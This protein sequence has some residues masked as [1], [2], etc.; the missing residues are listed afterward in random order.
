VSHSSR[1]EANISTE[2]EV[3]ALQRILNDARLELGRT[4]DQSERQTLE[5]YCAYMEARLAPL[6]ATPN[7]AASND[8][9]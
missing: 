1:L 3:Q 4:L 2:A 6:L 9:S 8:T 5:Y 7:F